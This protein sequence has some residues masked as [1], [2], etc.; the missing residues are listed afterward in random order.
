VGGRRVSPSKQQSQ[1]LRH[2]LR[3]LLTPTTLTVALT[4]TLAV[5]G[6]LMALRTPS[7]S[8]LATP[9]GD[10]L[11]ALCLALGLAFIGTE[12]A[13]A[14]IEVR[15]QAYS[16]SLSG[17][18]LLIGLLYLPPHVLVPLRLG[19]TV[20]VF[21][22]QRSS[23][24][25]LGYNTAAFL[26]DTALVITLA[27]QLLGGHATLSLRTAGLCYL[28]LAVVDVVMSSLV[29]LVIRINQGPLSLLEAAEVLVP[30]SA[31]VALNTAIAL[32]C[33]LLV[34]AG[35]LGVLLFVV[36]AVLTVVGYRA[37]LVLRRRHQSLRVVQE[38]IRRGETAESVQQLCIELSDEARSLLR[39]QR[40][41][42]TLYP[43]DQGI[44]NA[45]NGFRVSISDEGSVVTPSTDRSADWLPRN[46]I[47]R[48]VGILVTEKSKE[49]G[50]RQWL[51]EQDICDALIAPLEGSNAV[52]VALDRLGDATRFTKDDLALL[53][54]LTG[55]FSVALESRQ[56][57]ERLQ[58][59]ANH[60][61]LTDLPNRAF[62][63]TRVRA[64]LDQPTAG[65][66]P[67]VLLLDLNRFKEVNDALGHHIGDQL[68][69]VV[70]DRL[71]Q[72]PL[73][74]ATVSRLGGDE[75]ALLLPPSTDPH[76]LATSVAQSICESLAIPV[77][78]ADVTITTEA[79]IGIAV[80]EE[81]ESHTDLL[82]HADTAM[83]AAKGAGMPWEI[84][85]PQ[86]D[87]GRSERLAL[88]SD[89]KHAIDR[90]ELHLHY[91]P[92]L[93]LASG[94]I[95]SVE[96]LVRWTHPT[97][98]PLGPD[99]FIPLAESTGLIEQLTV[100][101]LDNALRQC[102]VWERQGLNL[103]VAVN[104]SARNVNNP[105]LPDLVAS[106]LRKAGVSAGHLVLEIT[107]SA[108]MGDPDRT[109]PT[110]NQ[111]ADLGI[112]LSLDDFG[113]G[114]S[115]LSYLQR[116]PVREV[117][118][119]RSFI[120]GMNHPVEGRASTAL[121]RSIVSLGQSLGLRIVAEGIETEA[122]LAAVHALG[123]HVVQG[124]YIGRP[125]PGHEI[126]EQHSH[127]LGDCI[128]EGVRSSR[129]S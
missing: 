89:L 109:I 39:A 118:I 93:D 102:R 23:G 107:E 11:P 99:V 47:R 96:A 36:F 54:T 87:R 85:S 65:S 64:M 18:P 98:G 53:V 69:K 28:T 49:P 57:V 46:V 2:R 120:L 6:L 3:R 31:F 82:R 32:T 50:H 16:F 62:L 110:L 106:A 40:L 105:E 67:T 113:T 1:R 127:R 92:K 126:T 22:L 83:Y 37:Y 25:K 27:N 55:H 14:F 38:F 101:V 58:Y 116:L 15:S 95:S 30:A 44:G 13:Q 4:S 66:A 90:D 114:Y 117:K 60:D 112:T 100:V 5:L 48:G 42:F 125:V 52:L 26:L 51:A 79:C 35:N 29:L 119:D 122:S 73:E 111:L 123:C 72:L 128:R 108:M 63:T 56:L 121:V 81:G 80:A 33:V 97:L 129:H 75:F 19:A 45:T 124:Y 12:L 70:G 61:V 103:A 88:V 86:L 24:L 74:H 68:L 84:Y 77:D 10:R 104:L 8:L 21:V 17:V 41:E 71:N 20:L 34:R 7:Q 43:P 76:R 9:P 115:S 91:Q 94:L 78:L 59:E